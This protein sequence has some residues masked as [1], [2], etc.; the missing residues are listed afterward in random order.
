M[1]N[2]SNKSKLSKI[3]SKD[4]S[5]LEKAQWREDNEAWLEKS[6]HIAL[7]IVRT[8]RAELMTQKDLAKRMKVTPQHVNKILKGSENLTLETIFKL[9]QALNIS[10]I[11]IQSFPS[12]TTIQEDLS[13]DTSELA[14][15][16]SIIS[17]NT[18]A[19]SVYSP[20]NENE[21]QKQA[22]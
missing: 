11:E 15:T 3:A 1:E 9:E 5:W 20:D 16:F 12:E 7:R 22:A 17:T 14:M 8:L 4:S 18:D 10:L 19:F 21:R 13:E 2:Q 6:A